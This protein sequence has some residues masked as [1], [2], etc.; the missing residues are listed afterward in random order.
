MS[1]LSY[2]I[3]YVYRT[4]LGH[5][6]ILVVTDEVTNYLVTIQLWRGASHE[7]VEALLNYVFCKMSHSCLIFNE[8]QAFLSSIMPYSYKRLGIK[9]KTISPYNHGSLKAERHIRTI[10][11]M[12]AKQ[13]TGI[14]QMWT[15]IIYKCLPMHIILLA[16]PTLNGFSSFQL[17]YGRPPEVMYSKI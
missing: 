6:F 17:M 9:L 2:H 4:S 3:T 13:L 12:L 10:N 15:H 16:S 11:E 14:K 5:S 8:N 7:V 1:K